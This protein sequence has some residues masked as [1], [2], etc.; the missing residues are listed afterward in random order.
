MSQTNTHKILQILAKDFPNAKSELNFHNPFELIVAVIL[1]AQC[2]DKRVN[3]VTPKLFEVAPTPDAL[4]NLPLSIIEEIIR[5]CG[6]YHSKATYLKEMASDLVTRFGGN[7]PGNLDDLQTLKGVGRKTANVV[8]AVAFGG[9][10]IAVDTHVFRVSN[11]L[12]IANAKNVLDTEK[13]LMQAIP[14][15]MW[16]DSHHYILLHGRYV[17]KAQNPQCGSCSVQDYCKYYQQKQLELAQT[18]ASKCLSCKNASCQAHCPVANDIPNVTKAVKAGKYRQAVQLIGHPF[19]EVCGYVCPHNIQCRGNCILSGKNNAVDFPKMERTIFAQYPFQW[20][21]SSSAMTGKKVAVIG[22]G[23]SGVT[24]ASLMYQEGASVT[25]FEQNKLLATLQLI[26]QY[27]LPKQ[28]LERILNNIPKDV[29][30]IYEAVDSAKLQTL[31]SVF[32]VVY[33][34]VGAMQN[35][36]L[37]VDGEDFA[38]SSTQCLQGQLQGKVVVV[39]GGNTAIDCATYAKSL[40]CDVTIA[41]RRT[42]KDMPAFAEEIAFAKKEGVKFVFNVAPQKCSYNNA[43]LYLQLRKTVSNGRGSL[44]LTDETVNIE[45]DVVVSAIG[46]SVDK[47]LFDGQKPNPNQYGQ[48]APNLFVGGDTVGAGLVAKAVCDAQNTAKYILNKR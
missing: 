20:K 48:I 40:G 43:K 22:G 6:F 16:S 35:Y 42:E 5:P 28:S 45:C 47:N 3:L 26:P 17:C 14:R 38:I 36:S 32:D 30:I 10:A 7:V 34:A 2:T 24:F 12:G 21:V 15:D 46:T 44:Q 25:I 1:S 13:Q 11:R 37:G 9:Q 39:G 18:E 19:G 23:V 29:D 33:V 31:Q 27:R 8:F 41:Y 4:A